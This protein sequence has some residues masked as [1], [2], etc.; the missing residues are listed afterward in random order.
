M[1]Q[2]AGQSMQGGQ[3]GSSGGGQPGG[4]YQ[5]Y[6]NQFAGQYM[7]GGQN[8]SN[9]RS[10]QSGDYQQYMKQY[11]GQYMQGGQHRLTQPS[12]AN[13][14]TNDQQTTQKKGSDYQ[15]QYASQYML[16]G[17]S[18][19]SGAGQPGGNY[20]QYMDRY[21]GQHMES[22]QNGS[23]KGSQQG[24]DYQQ[25]MR[26]YAGQY[27]KGYQNGSHTGSQQSGGQKWYQQYLDKYGGHHANRQEHLANFSDALQ[28]HQY[29]T[30]RQAQHEIMA[31]NT[32]NSHRLGK[33]VALD[34]QPLP[35]L[36][37]HNVSATS[38]NQSVNLR[39]SSPEAMQ[40]AS[41]KTTSAHYRHHVLMCLVAVGVPVF[42]A[43]SLF[44]VRRRRIT[45]QAEQDSYY[46]KVDSDD[47]RTGACQAPD[48]AS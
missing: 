47:L 39:G 5:Q 3:S 22:G 10:Q 17:Q 28:K 37:S 40:L 21:V 41:S 46:V 1:Q 38:R 48:L 4:N 15:Q 43:V 23:N 44:A 19:S 8:G 9:T 34:E 31:G 18:G 24:G 2:Y 29:A 35:E 12:S 32:T 26:Q 16:G 36:R 20:Q 6:M 42:I 11:A 30:S 33:H 25:Y 13:S 27:I 14:S 7:Q 45:S